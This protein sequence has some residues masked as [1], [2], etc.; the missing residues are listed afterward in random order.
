[1]NLV[2]QFI[3][4]Q[5]GNVIIL[6]G[7]SIFTL[8]AIVGAAVDLGRSQI[9]QL[10]LQQ[11]SDAAALAAAR[12]IGFS[13]TERIEVAQR[14]FALNFPDNYMGSDVTAADM[15]L[16]FLP[17][18]E[19][20]RAVRI[21]VDSS[22]DTDFIQFVGV[23]TVGVGANT[24]V[25]VSGE[26]VDLDVILVADGTS[27]MVINNRIQAL[28]DASRTFAD[29]LLNP[30]NL[31]PGDQIRVSLFEYGIINTIYGGGSP[32]PIVLDNNGTPADPSDDFYRA[33]SIPLADMMIPKSEQNF[34]DSLS[35]VNQ[36]ISNFSASLTPTLITNGGPAALETADRII[37]APAQPDGTTASTKAWIFLTDGLFNVPWP[38]GAPIPPQLNSASPDSIQLFNNACDQLRAANV[39]RYTIALEAE[40]FGMVPTLRD[41]ASIPKS[42][43]FYQPMSGDSLEDV[44]RNIALQLRTL[45]ITK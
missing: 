38:V 40:S 5:Q 7:L 39:I 23:N 8:I 14:M 35:V 10:K 33:P 1:M 37:N 31:N 41:C 32:Y 20:L 42:D 3:R 43:H 36:G 29:I 11:A 30:A 22:I 9:L 6:I 27:S 26:P 13:A 18:A 4:S 44:F 17:N 16:T 34:S 12:G 24:E 19:N 28:K 21:T 45:V 15:S 2:Q 25:S